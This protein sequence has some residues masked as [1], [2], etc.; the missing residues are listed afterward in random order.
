M[1]FTTRKIQAHVKAMQASLQ[2]AFLMLFAVI[3][4]HKALYYEEQ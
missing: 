3:N 2:N 4:M 1:K